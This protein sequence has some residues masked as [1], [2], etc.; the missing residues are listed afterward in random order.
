MRHE[1]E[2]KL[3]V[4]DRR[5]IRRRLGELGFKPAV[6][7][8]F[9]RNSLL[10]FP[11]RRLRKEG[12]LLRLRYAGGRSLLTFKGR[13]VRSGRFK[14]R[15]EIETRLTD[16]ALVLDIL[17]RLGLR[18]AFRYEKYRTIF[19]RATD[20]GDTE[21]AYDETPIGT[22]LELEGPRRW[23]DRVAGELSYRP[24]DYITASY[25]RLYL[26]WCEAHGRTPTHM[27]FAQPSLE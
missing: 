24:T 13:R 17:E 8:H 9:E 3:P 23:I 14:V 11:D 15:P 21:I 7:R 22:Y 20:P 2:I 19:H 26:W 18:V 5:A 27:V 6:K 12:C 10:D 16:G 4:A 25:G 1:I